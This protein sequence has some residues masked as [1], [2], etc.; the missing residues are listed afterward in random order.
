MQDFE[1]LGTFV[2]CRECAAGTRATGEVS[3]SYD[4][5]NLTTHAV[6]V[7]MAASGKDGH[8]FAQVFDV[9]SATAPVNCAIRFNTEVADMPHAAECFDIVQEHLDASRVNFARNSVAFPHNV[10]TEKCG[11][12]SRSFYPCKPDISAGALSLWRTPW[13]RL[14]K[15]SVAPA[16]YSRDTE[17]QC[18]NRKRP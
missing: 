7:D 14:S 15:R 5:K 3:F 18:S 8:G 16:R 10:T 6:V 2:L 9:E 17:S 4:S 1:N 13:K 11:V 12:Q